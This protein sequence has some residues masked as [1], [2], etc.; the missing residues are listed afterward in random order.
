MIWCGGCED[1]TVSKWLSIGGV[2]ACGLLTVYVLRARFRESPDPRRRHW[3]A[4]WVH[5][6]MPLVAMP[7]GGFLGAWVYTTGMHIG[8]NEPLRVRGNFGVFLIAMVAGAAAAGFG[9]VVLSLFIV[10]RKLSV[11]ETLDLADYLPMTPRYRAFSAAS[12]ESTRRFLDW[13]G[14]GEVPRS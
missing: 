9:G 5:V 4:W 13:L 14:L 6:L 7:L 2:T 12:R 3:W 10:R 1:S 11:E 8:M